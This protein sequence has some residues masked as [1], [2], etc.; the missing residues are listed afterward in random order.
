MGRP[1]QRSQE[2]LIP[3]QLSAGGSL[4][5]R[6]RPKEDESYLGFLIRLAELNAYETPFRIIQA[7]RLRST[8][9]TGPQCES[10]LE[11]NLGPLADLC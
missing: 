5:I 10:N 8:T 2:Q 9:L 4:V 7:A 1:P 11:V 6:A 3:D